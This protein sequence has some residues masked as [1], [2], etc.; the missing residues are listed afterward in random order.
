[1]LIYLSFVFKTSIFVGRHM[2]MNYFLL[3]SGPKP[4]NPG[5]CAQGS[6]QYPCP[7]NC[8]HH[9]A[10]HQGVVGWP[11]PV[12]AQDSCPRHTEALQVLLCLICAL[13]ASWLI[14][15]R[16][17]IVG[18]KL[19]IENACIQHSSL[20]AVTSGGPNWVTNCHSCCL[21]VFLIWVNME[22]RRKL[23]THRTNKRSESLSFSSSLSSVSQGNAASLQLAS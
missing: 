5:Q 2:R 6:V 7:Y 15:M 12:C 20:T 18:I 11:L 23:V 22:R 17:K 9:D 13:D 4:V 19:E 8:S 21:Q 16:V 14:Y 10:G 3:A 1:M